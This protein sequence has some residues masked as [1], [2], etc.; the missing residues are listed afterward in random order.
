TRRNQRGGRRARGVLQGEEGCWSVVSS[1]IC[2][3]MSFH[4][5]GASGPGVRP[6]PRGTLGASPVF[7]RGGPW[8]ATFPQG[9]SR[10]AGPQGAG[11]QGNGRDSQNTWAR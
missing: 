10:G 9:L 1:T 4:G 6:L 11:A 5:E 3:G 7:G 2:M 8:V